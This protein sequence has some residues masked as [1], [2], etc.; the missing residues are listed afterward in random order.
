MT[1]S[2]LGFGVYIENIFF[3]LKN[4]KTIIENLSHILPGIGTI[5]LAFEMNN[6]GVEMSIEK[7]Q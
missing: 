4:P 6:L 2:N 7:N 5:S 1:R 3:T